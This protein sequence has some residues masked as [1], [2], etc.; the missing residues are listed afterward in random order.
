MHPS[1]YVLL[2]F[3][4]IC[5]YILSIRSSGKASEE[6]GR[7]HIELTVTQ[8]SRDSLPHLYIGICWFLSIRHVVDSFTWQNV[9]A[10]KGPSSVAKQVQ[11][12]LIC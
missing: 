8:W 4:Y 1:F 5:V 7:V 2:T 3:V 6:K 9:S 11:N 12:K 10:P